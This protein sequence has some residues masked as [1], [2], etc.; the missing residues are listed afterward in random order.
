MVTSPNKINE[1]IEI[2][3][4]VKSVLDNKCFGCHNTDSK[5]QKAKDKM[6]LDKLG[7]LSKA[8]M[9]ATLG[10]ISEVASEGKMPPEKFLEQRPEKKLTEE[11][12]N[13]L[14][15]WA[16]ETSNALLK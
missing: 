9:I 12:Q 13:L 6:L 15:I 1:D 5:A 4:N 10:K 16:E 3:D 8:K 2:P 11:E 7:E 14:V